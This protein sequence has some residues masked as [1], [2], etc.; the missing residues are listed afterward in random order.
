LG[1][2]EL[3]Q[4]RALVSYGAATLTGYVN[5]DGEST[6]QYFQYGLT[7]DCGGQTAIADAGTGTSTVKVR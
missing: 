6:S 5:P 7:R 4:P 2:R 3:T 1:A